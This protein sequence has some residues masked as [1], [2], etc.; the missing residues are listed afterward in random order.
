MDAKSPTKRDVWV[1]NLDKCIKEAVEKDLLKRPAKSILL[2]SNNLFFLSNFI[3]HIL[4]KEDLSPYGGVID[5]STAEIIMQEHLGSGGSGCRV[6]K[7]T[8]DGKPC[9]I[10]VILFNN[11]F[12]VFLFLLR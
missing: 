5:F 10:K 3:L 9:A 4:N 7:C 1:A 12:I 2:I 6:E 11:I 8:V